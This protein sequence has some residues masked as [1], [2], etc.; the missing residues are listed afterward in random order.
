ML[1]NLKISARLGLGFGCVVALLL[2]VSIISIQRL[3]ASNELTRLILEDRYAK[4]LLL[5]DAVKNSMD[6]ARQLR[7]ILLSSNDAE[8]ERYRRVAEGNRAEI[9][10]DLNK[11]QKVVVLE[12]GKVMLKD[13]QDKRAALDPKYDQF[14][15]IAR[16]DRKAAAEYVKTEF[17]PAN[18]AFF[19][20]L[21][22]L[23]KFQSELM[24]KS[25]DEVAA[26]Y[27]ATRTL[28]ISL[29]VGAVL[30]ACVVAYLITVGIVRPLQTAVQ[31]AER[32]EGGDL[33]M[34]ID[35]SA[36]DETGQLLN[37]MRNMVA[38]L[39]RVISGQKQAIEASNRG[40][41][42]VRVEL[43][44]LH[45]FQ[46]ELAEGLNQLTAT[47]GASVADV[48]RVMGALSEG[49]LSKT[50]TKEYQGSLDELKR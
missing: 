39:N 19:Q 3:A 1:K 41:F 43:D 40:D 12:K 45:G 28:V 46:K 4:F 20:A 18:E 36:R 44:G 15:A 42:S 14:Y 21:E 49:D 7:N 16:T 2:L 10:E 13:I 32:L 5:D 11:L 31:V 6:N 33:S 30:M 17:A 22:A 34:Q 8:S 38:K 23:A 9:V 25:G 35:G 47:T 50:I 27:E 26:S 37:A 48:V 29:V 24:D